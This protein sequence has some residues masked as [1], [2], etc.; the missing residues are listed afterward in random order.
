[1]K[2][3]FVT[4]THV[5]LKS[6][7]QNIL[8]NQLKAWNEMFEYM[9]DNSIRTIFHLGDFTDNRKAISL[10]TLHYMQSGI[11]DKLV[12]YDFNM[13]YLVGNHD[14]NLRTTLEINSMSLFE[15]AY[16]D[17]FKVYDKPETVSFDGIKFQ[18]LPWIIDGA[19]VDYNADIILC[20]AEMKDFYVIV[21]HKSTHGLSKDIFRDKTV[22]SGH[23]HI[24]Q[25]EGKIKYLGNSFIQQNWSDFKEKKGFWVFET[26]DRT[27]E[28]I[29]SKSTPKHVKCH[30]DSDLKTVLIQGL[31]DIDETYKLDSKFDYNLLNNHKLKVYATKEL[32]IVKKFIEMIEPIVTS[33]KLEIMTADEEI[34]ISERIE[35][36]KDYS[37]D[38]KIV[39]VCDEEDKDTVVSIIQ[40]AKGMMKGDG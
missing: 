36:A 13:S 15:K 37:I 3:A 10:N 27:I 22:Y 30:I 21:G 34:D 9:K 16:K 23:Y 26:N 8:D 31:N 2:I 18:F 5:D 6:G 32:A 35:K 1:M 38:Q 28:F 33:W 29:E 17:N 4:D 39:S 24:A 19:E 12:E 7:N 40:E 25:S 11:F 20:H 14:I